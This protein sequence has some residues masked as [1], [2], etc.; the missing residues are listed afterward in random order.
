MPC[1]LH[2]RFV[3]FSSLPG[4]A[5]E[6]LQYSKSLSSGE[7][8]LITNYLTQ[9]W[10]RTG[11]PRTDRRRTLTTTCAACYRA[12]SGRTRCSQ[13]LLTSDTSSPHEPA[14]D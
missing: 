8:A 3:R 12:C 6:V 13:Q 11:P 5:H 1:V 10:V 9:K 2:H 14:P 4:C 7:L